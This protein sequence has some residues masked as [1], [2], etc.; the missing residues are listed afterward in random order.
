M[1]RTIYSNFLLL[2]LAFTFI[3]SGCASLPLI[4]SQLAGEDPYDGRYYFDVESN[5]AYGVQHD[6]EN[7][8]IKIKTD[9]K[10]AIRKIMMQGLY[11]YIDPKAG[12]SKNIYFNYPLSEKFDPSQKRNKS[13]GMEQGTQQEFNVEH[14][15]DRVSM[16]AV[17]SDHELAEKLPVFSSKTDIL[18]ELI[19]EGP[20]VLVYYLRMPFDRIS[21]NGLSDISELSLGFMT[22]KMEMPKMD[23]SGH[24]G[25]GMQGG[26]GS[27][28]GGMQG[29]DMQ[30]S[31]M[32]RESMMSQ[33][34][35]WFKI[36]LS[37]DDAK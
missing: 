13:A 7:L 24:S 10:A 16:E 4:E 28:S 6:D 25:G 33:L 20:N 37:P 1:K 14:F 29:G 26:G 34:S 11:V 31:G 15:L 18:V 22:G 5:I 17:F 35:I 23:G 8:Y 19:S 9:D 30:S 12:K 21:K 32:E 2:I 3:L 36:D 27:S